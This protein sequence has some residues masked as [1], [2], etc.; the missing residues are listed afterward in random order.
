[1]TKKR[2]TTGDDYLLDETIDLV[3]D[4]FD[5][6]DFENDAM[7]DPNDHEY[8]QEINNDETEGQPLPLDRYF[9]RFGK[10]SKRNR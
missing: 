6:E 3:D 5:V 10:G 8:L 4:V 7:F 9:S 2:Y 1:M